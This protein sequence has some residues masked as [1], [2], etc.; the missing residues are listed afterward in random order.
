MRPHAPVAVRQAFAAWR[1]Q[2]HALP[3][4]MEQSGRTQDEAPRRW[5]GQSV[6]RPVEVEYSEGLGAQEKL[7]FVVLHYTGVY[8][9]PVAHPPLPTH[10]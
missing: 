4:L 7:R 8:R 2:Q 6:L 3:L 9:E 5:H 10:A 1:R